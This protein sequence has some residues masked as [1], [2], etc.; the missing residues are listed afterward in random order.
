M[1]ATHEPRRRQDARTGRSPRDLATA[2]RRRWHLGIVVAPVYL[3]NG[4]EIG[5]FDTIPATLA[6]AVDRPGGWPAPRPISAAAA[7]VGDA[8]AGVR[9]RVR[10]ACHLDAI[11]SGRRWWRCR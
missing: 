2:G 3:A 6:P 11:R 5:A 7:D 1:T 8:P 4:R 10:R 9:R